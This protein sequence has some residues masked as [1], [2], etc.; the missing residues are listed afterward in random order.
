MQQGQWLLFENAH[1]LIQF[2]TNL[3]K[4]L[5]NNEKSHP[6]F[7]LFLTTDPT[8]SFPIGFLQRSLKGWYKLKHISKPPSEYT[9]FS[10][11]RTTNWH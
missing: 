3:E 1:L 10:C 11:Q 8:P 2:I 4:L 7:R 5:E 9:D 6:N